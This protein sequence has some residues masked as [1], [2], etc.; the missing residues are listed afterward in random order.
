MLLGELSKVALLE[1]IGIQPIIFQTLTLQLSGFALLIIF[2][3]IGGYIGWTRGLRIIL[4]PAFMTIVAYVLTVRGGDII[5]DIVNRFWVNGPKL[6]AF[7]V[8]RD[9]DTVP[10]LDPL[11]A[12]DFQVPLFFRFTFFVALVAFGLAFN[13]KSQWYGPRKEQFSPLLGLFTGA[14][15]AL[16]WTDALATFV[17]QAGGLGGP[18]GNVFG[19]IPD[20]GVFIPS[21]ITIFF[22]ILGLI[23][24]FNLPKVWKA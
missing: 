5:V 14:L 20:V 24:L 10:P 13:K 22:L 8:G 2:M 1:N 18:L 9:P 21:L 12:T 6:A 11:I 19:I 23:I 15:T 7:A 16:L 4:T 3:A 17:R